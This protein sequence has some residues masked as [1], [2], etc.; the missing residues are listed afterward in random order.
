MSMPCDAYLRSTCDGY[1]GGPLTV[2]QFKGGQS[3]PTF[4]LSRRR[5]HYVLRTKPGP[6]AKL[7]PSAHAID[8]EFRVMDALHKAGFP[9]PRQ[10]ALC[11]DES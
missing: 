2:E 6:A 3:N 9:A 11:T 4:K 10:Y 8:R 5:Q 7:L 1:P